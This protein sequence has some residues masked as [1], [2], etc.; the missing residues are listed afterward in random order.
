MSNMLRPSHLHEVTGTPLGEAPKWLYPDD[1]CFGAS[2]TFGLGITLLFTALVGIGTAIR[3]SPLWLLTVPAGPVAIRVFVLDRR[4]Q[5][6]ARFARARIRR[7]ECIRCGMQLA[8]ES[9]RDCCE[10]GGS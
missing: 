3:S 5:S 9:A 1:Q 4:F 8:E 10:A 2:F 6:R 7:H